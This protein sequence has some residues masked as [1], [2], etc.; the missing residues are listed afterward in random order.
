M[1]VIHTKRLL[2]LA[3]KLETMDTITPSMLTIGWKN[4]VGDVFEKTFI[5]YGQNMYAVLDTFPEDWKY[6]NDDILVLTEDPE[7]GPLVGMLE[8][9]SLELWEYTHLFCPYL[10]D[11]EIYGGKP[12]TDEGKGV[13]PQDIAYNIREFVKR[14]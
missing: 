6:I 11:V 8:F 4:G 13:T 1:K 2:M 7:I 10:Q 12:L 14:K 9:F 3:D 5:D